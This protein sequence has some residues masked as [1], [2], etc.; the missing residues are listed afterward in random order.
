MKDY[1]AS[2]PVEN[3]LCGKALMFYPHEQVIVTLVDL[4]VVDIGGTGFLPELPFRATLFYLH[5]EY[6]RN[7][8]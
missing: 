8:V 3:S 5:K 7:T 2:L 1:K 4:M 6:S